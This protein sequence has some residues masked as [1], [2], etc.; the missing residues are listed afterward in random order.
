MMRA[1]LS[2]LSIVPLCVIVFSRP[3]SAGWFGPSTYD[4]C[5]LDEM[6]GRPQYMMGNVA[7]VCRSKFCTFVEA[8]QE[9]W[10]TFQQSI[11]NCKQEQGGGQL[12]DVICGGLNPPGGYDCK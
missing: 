9:Q 11:A 1:V 5:V 6:K 2:V 7:N 12:A 3:A 8:T 10:V 4:E